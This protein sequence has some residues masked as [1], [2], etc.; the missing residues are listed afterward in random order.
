M[1]VSIE[2]QG[3][4]GLNALAFQKRPVVRSGF[5]TVP[6][7]TILRGTHAYPVE[8]TSGNT[9]LSGLAGLGLIKAVKNTASLV[10]AVTDAKSQGVTFSREDVQTIKNATAGTAAQRVQQTTDVVKAVTAQVASTKMTPPYAQN[11]GLTAQTPAAAVPAVAQQSAPPSP[12]MNNGMVPYTPPAPP[13]MSYQ[14]P[15]AP[16]ASAYAPLPTSPYDA[17]M[18]EQ[19]MFAPVPT[20]QDAAAAYAMNAPT[21]FAPPQP[22]K[23]YTPWIIGGGVGLVALLGIALMGSRGSSEGSGQ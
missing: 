3:L 22:A 9:D 2:V 20:S 6:T 15:A 12:V 14:S 11:A 10:R 8:I 16:A 18:P 17:P 23:N 19:P 5:P 7:P 13:P 21:Q 1:A 4:N